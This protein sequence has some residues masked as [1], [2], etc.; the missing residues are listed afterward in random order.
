M[1]LV[2]D[3][4]ADADSHSTLDRLVAAEI[5]ALSIERQQV[6]QD[7]EPEEDS[8][9]NALTLAEIRFLDR[10]S[11]WLSAR[12]D[13]AALLQQL[14]DRVLGGVDEPGNGD[15]NDVPPSDPDPDR[16]DNKIDADGT[17]PPDIAGD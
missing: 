3:E 10:A 6:P 13:P 14:S 5:E 4:R 2:R 1:T 7:A 16:E 15:V 12:P 11:D 17:P 9:D 8:D